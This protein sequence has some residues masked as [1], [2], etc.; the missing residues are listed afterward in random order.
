M[1]TRGQE[2]TAEQIEQLKALHAKSMSCS[3]IAAEIGCGFTRNAIIGKL[4]RMGLS[5]AASTVRKHKWGNRPRAEKS[6]TRKTIRVVRANGNSD[7]MHFMES[8]ETDIAALRCI[9]VDPLHVPLIDL[10]GCRYPYGEGPFTFCNHPK[11]E[12]S[13]YCGPHF[14]LARTSTRKLSDA[15]REQ[16][17]RTMRANYKLT[18]MEAAE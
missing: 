6:V 5:N 14:A 3:L 13:S 7:R 15:G 11:F 1:R 17:R 16:R 4:H 12:G 8:P 10:D 18:L 2:W 9:E